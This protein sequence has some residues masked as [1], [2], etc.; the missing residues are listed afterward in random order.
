M[1]RIGVMPDAHGLLG[2]QAIADFRGVD[3]IIHAGNMGKEKVFE[4][5]RQ[6]V[7]SN[8]I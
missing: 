5:L 7:Y 1:K 8:I 4:E 2:A 6:V 3:L